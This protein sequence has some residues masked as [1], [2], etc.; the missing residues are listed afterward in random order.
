[1]GMIMGMFFKIAGGRQLFIE[2]AR[3]AEPDTFF[4]LRREGR[5]WIFW[6]G[7]WHGIYTPRNWAPARQQ[8][9]RL[10]KGLARDEGSRWH[11]SWGR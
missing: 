10:L 2:R 4:H 9:R 6:I 7:R 3:W 11:P 8:R 1:M 5:E